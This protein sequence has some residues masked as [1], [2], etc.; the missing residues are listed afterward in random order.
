[1]T[2]RKK[3]EIA[4]CKLYLVESSEGYNGAVAP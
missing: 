3:I 2:K 1:M 4:L